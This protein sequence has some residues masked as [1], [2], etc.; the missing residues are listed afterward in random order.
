LKYVLQ[1]LWAVSNNEAEYEAVLHGLRL[2]ISLG[3]KPLLVYGNSLLVVQKV[4]KEWDCNKETMEAYVQEVRKLESKFSGL[5][6]HHV[7]QEHNVGLDILS[8]MGSTRAQVPP[9]VFFQELKQPSIKSSPQETINAGLQQPDRE[10]MMLGEDWREAFIDFIRDQRLP[11]GI[12]ARSAEAACVLRRRKGFVLVDGKLYRRGAWSGV[13]MK[14]VT[15]EDGYD[16]LR[17][18]HK[19]VCGNHAASRTLVGKAYRTGF[20]WPTAVIDREDL[21]RRCQN[22]QFFGKRTHV[23][24]HSLITIPPSW[25]FACWS[26]N[27][28]GPFPKVPG[29]FTHVLVAIDKFTKWI[30]YKP[31]AKLTPDWVVDF[32]SDI[33]HRF[34]FPNTIITDLGSNF[35]AN[36]FWEF[37]ENACIEVKYVS[38]AHPRANGQVE[39]ANGLIIDG[40]KKRLYDENSKKGG[41]WVHELPHVVWGFGLSRPKPQDKRLFSSYTDLKLFYQPISCGSLQG[42]KCIMKARRT[43]RVS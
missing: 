14:C 12:D 29:G 41:K 33:L 13:L 16:I 4:N 38:V 1:I 36:Q 37:C 11:V 2:A 39:R 30:E 5:E 43:R 35:I 3:I 8:K 7:L 19:G 24:A 20:W 6:V 34:G 15:K 22:C 10:V 32:I 27:M 9:G 28:I 18:I 17:E 23:P 42:S 25:P 26:L 31:I 40:L 21:V